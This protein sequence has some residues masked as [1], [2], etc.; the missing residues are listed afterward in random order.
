[1]ILTGNTLKSQNYGDNKKT[2]VTR[3]WVGGWDEEVG[4]EHL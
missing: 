3:G 1:M 2:G 4:R